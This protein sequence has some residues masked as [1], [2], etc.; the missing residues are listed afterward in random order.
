[1]DIE[2]NEP[3]ALMCD[4]PKTLH[5]PGKIM[6]C[7]FCGVLAILLVAAVLAVAGAALHRIS[8]QSQTYFGTIQAIVEHQSFALDHTNYLGTIDKLSARGH[9]YTHKPLLLPIIGSV[10]YWPLWRAGL[11][12]DGSTQVAAEVL[13]TVSLIGGSYL[14]AIT[15]FYW[16]VG[17]VRLPASDRAALTGALAFSTLLLPFSTVLNGQA[18]AAHWITVGFACLLRSTEVRHGRLQM[19]I[20]GLAFAVATGVDH[21][22]AAFVGTLTL[23]L[24]IR[25]RSVADIVMFGLPVVVVM[26][27]ALYV[28]WMLSGSP[29]PL[30]S[31]TELF[32]YPGSYW[33]GGEEALTGN[34]NSFGFAV[35]YGIECLFGRNGFLWY[36][37]ILLLGLFCAIQEI[38]HRG[39]WWVE[40]AAVLCATAAI[41]VFY[42]LT[43]SNYSGWSY[44][45]RWFLLFVAPGV[46]FVFRSLQRASARQHRLFITLA[47]AGLVIAL[48]GCVDPWTPSSRY[49]AFIQNIGPRLVKGLNAISGQ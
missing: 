45:I 48:V 44:S 43:S 16:A 5:A 14:L 6:H 23:C 28:N 36:N 47:A 11:K 20:A 33:A 40:A 35:R 18:F 1:M 31:Q 27:V 46:F 41:I 29:R 49:P 8:A 34:R 26:A 21:A 9:F 38:R 3:H 19:A 12:L 25:R 30:S 17:V 42:S 7:P 4:Y 13:L 39:P 24:V 10:F 32:F 15:A 22:A 2:Q 37:P